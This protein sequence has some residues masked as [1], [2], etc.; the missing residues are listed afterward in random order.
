MQA[1]L[2]HYTEED[3]YQTVHKF[4][5]QPDL[6]HYDAYIAQYFTRFN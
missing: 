1:F 2:A 4:N 6:F 3:L 5:H